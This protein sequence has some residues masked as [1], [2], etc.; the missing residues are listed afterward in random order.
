MRFGYAF[1]AAFSLPLT[2]CANANFY[3]KDKWIAGDF[4]RG[5]NW[6]TEDDPTHGRVNFV[7]QAEAIAKNLSYGTIFLRVSCHMRPFDGDFFS[8]E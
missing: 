1:L 6:E 7:S 5:W 3:L 2:Q 4:F 8:G